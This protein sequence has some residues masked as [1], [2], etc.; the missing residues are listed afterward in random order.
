VTIENSELARQ[1]PA[2]DT[3]RAVGSF[4]VL[5]THVAFWTGAYTDLEVVGP[6]LA[7]MD[8]GVALFFVLSGF[9]LSRQWMVRAQLG[10]PKPNL[11][12]YLV[13]RALRIWPVYIVTAVLALTFISDNA[14]RSAGEWLAT[15]TL[16]DIYVD[17]VLPAGLTQMWSLATEVAFYLVLPT[18]MFMVIPRGDAKPASGLRVAVLVVL[19]VV[20][21]VFWHIAWSERVPGAEDRAVGQW[22]PAYTS[23]FAAGI[24]LA[25]LQVRHAAGRLSLR[26]HTLITSL[27]SSPG[28]LWVVAGGLLLVASTPLAGPTTLDPATYGEAVTKNL[29]YAAVGGVLVFAGAFCRSGTGYTRIMHSRLAR[30]LGHISYSVFCIHLPV[31]HLV[32][33][34]TGYPLFQGHLLEVLALTTALSLLAAEALYRVVE[35]PFM[36]LAT[37]RRGRVVTS[38]APASETSAR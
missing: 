35:R 26:A 25:L 33:W 22:L 34:L 20:V 3:L 15:L 31:L 27:A 4:A 24:A 13:K 2:L 37:T 38:T 28:A 32:M 16:V 1:F 23:W 29:L 30:H 36:R 5:V 17:E 19:M 21:S 7:R 8:V 10:L 6:L 14:G 11:R 9:L 18:L 12:R